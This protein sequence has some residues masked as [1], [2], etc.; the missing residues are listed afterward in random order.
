MLDGISQNLE[1]FSKVFNIKWIF[2]IHK[3]QELFCLE[4]HKKVV[5]CCDP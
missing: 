4:E 1:G 2:K 5:I 3:F